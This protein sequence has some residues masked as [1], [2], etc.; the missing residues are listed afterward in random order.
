MLV[1]GLGLCVRGGGISRGEIFIMAPAGVL[2]PGQSEN[3]VNRQAQQ[4]RGD[5]RQ[6]NPHAVGL[7]ALADGGQ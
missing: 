1:L 4:Q 6:A 2:R 5:H 3:V 7:E